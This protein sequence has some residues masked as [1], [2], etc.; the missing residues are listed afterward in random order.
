MAA[1]TTV[2]DIKVKYST[3]RSSASSAHK[4]VK[5]LGFGATSA[6]VAVGMLGAELLKT[7]SR[8]TVSAMQSAVNIGFAFNKQIEDATITMAGLAQLNI[9]GEFA[10]NLIESNK[11]VKKFQQVAIKSTA[12]SK[13]FVEFASRIQGPIL[14]AGGS[15]NDLFQTTKAAVVAAKAFNIDPG[16]AALDIEQALAGTLTKRDRFARA[17]LEPMGF[18]TDKWNEMIKNKPASAVEELL[19]AFNNPAISRMAAAQEKSWSGVT[20]TIAD[21]RDRLAGIYSG[22]LFSAMKRFIDTMNTGLI[23]SMSGLEA[24]AEILGKN[25]SEVFNTVVM[26]LPEMRTVIKGLDLLRDSYMLAATTIENFFIGVHNNVVQFLNGIESSVLSV[27]NTLSELS[28]FFTGDKFVEKKAKLKK[29]LTFSRTDTGVLL[30]AFD[31]GLKKQKDK[32]TEEDLS[33]KKN[34]RRATQQ[35]VNVKISKIEVASDDPDRFAFNLVSAFQDIS[36]NPVQ[37]ANAIREG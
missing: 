20:S 25:L 12:T 18:A 29:E 3:D 17:L 36:K 14:R 22:P 16:L 35:Q 6:A 27:R 5:S 11:L 28:S 1:V 8:K 9:G 4:S 26:A 2:Y 7:F 19:K 32:I 31:E 37:A 13:E 34:N 33:D 24:V 21:L 10:D 15:M 30:K 23:K